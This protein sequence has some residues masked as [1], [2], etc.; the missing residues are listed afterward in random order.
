MSDNG[1][2]QDEKSIWVTADERISKQNKKFFSTKTFDLNRVIEECGPI[3]QFLIFR[4]DELVEKDGE[5]VSVEKLNIKIAESDPQYL[6]K[7]KS[8]GSYQKQGNNSTYRNQNDSGKPSG[9]QQY[10]RDNGRNNGV[11]RI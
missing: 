1:N 9:G 7:E 6:K 11:K 3:V 2:Y 5:Q 4:K 10:N 8:N